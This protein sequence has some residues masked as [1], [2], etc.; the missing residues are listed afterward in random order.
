MGGEI[1]RKSSPKVKGL[2]LLIVLFTTALAIGLVV[3]FRS[4][5]SSRDLLSFLTSTKAPNLREKP[6]MIRDVKYDARVVGER[7]TILIVG[8]VMNP[9]KQTADLNPLK[10]AVWGPCPQGQTGQKEEGKN[11]S[12]LIAT[13]QH[14]WDYATISPKERKLFQTVSSIPAEQAIERVDVTLP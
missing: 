6:L 10:I 1:A 5:T 2:I 13:W 7:K 9:H 12:C 8:E 14:T 3:L 4:S 11:G